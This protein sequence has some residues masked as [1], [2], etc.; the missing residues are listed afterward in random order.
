MKKLTLVSIMTAGL[1]SF[2]A[3]AEQ[4][5]SFDFVSLNYLSNDTAIGSQGGF[6][7][8][9]NVNITHGFFAETDLS[10]VSKSGNTMLS[11]DLG[12]GYAYHVLPSTALVASVGLSHNRF[13]PKGARTA[14]D[15]GQY[16]TL[17]VRSRAVH[18]D[19]ELGLRVNR[20]WMDYSETSY[21][22]SARYYV[23][24][25][26]SVELGYH[27][28]DSDFKAYNLGVAYHF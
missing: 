8:K 18:D 11:G 15:T 12:I 28:V 6:D 24:S 14:T 25:Q 5:P 22:A 27:Y 10:R 1:I 3:A 19:L 7:I 17:G 16:A 9:A 21:T 23:K 2:S 4:A 20:H 13:S 26:L